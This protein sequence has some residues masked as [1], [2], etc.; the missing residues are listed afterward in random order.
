MNGNTQSQKR[1]V[2]Y[3]VMVKDILK[4]NYV[5]VEG[6]T[7]NYLVLGDGKQISR[8]NLIGTIID[9]PLT[10]NPG[11]QNIVIDDGSGNIGIRTFEEK[12]ILNNFNIGDSIL[13]IGRPRE[14]GK[15]KYVIPEIIKK[16]EN[17]RWIELRKL[18]MG[19]SFSKE[20]KKEQPSKVDV[21]DLEE[22]IVVEDSNLFALIK[23]LDKGEG[24][25]FNEIVEKS[26]NQEAE[27]IINNMIK[28]GELFEI[29]PGKI[30]ILE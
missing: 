27:K 15:E 21:Y 24:A 5:K 16:I 20:Q 14:F 6:W 4:S 8:V 17:K 13:I 11:Y 12:G 1:N 2:A 3:K 26:N 29:N 19:V 18:E 9:K 7:P 25:D 28:Q 30:K 22:D 10:E 23:K